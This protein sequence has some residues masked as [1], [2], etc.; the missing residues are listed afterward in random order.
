MRFAT[1]IA[2]LAAKEFPALFVHVIPVGADADSLSIL[3]VIST[4]Y[5]SPATGLATDESEIESAC[6]SD[7]RVNIGGL[8]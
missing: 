2:K 5:L 8:G 7:D 3:V 6:L 4:K 1:P